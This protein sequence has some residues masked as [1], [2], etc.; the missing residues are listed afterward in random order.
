MKSI[1]INLRNKIR[2]A[3][4]TLGLMSRNWTS[5]SRVVAP[6]GPVV[7]LTTYGQRARTVFLTLESIARGDIQPSRLILWIDEDRLL[8]RIS[9][10]LRRLQRRGLEILRCED[11]GP[12]KKYYPY[13]R[14]HAEEGVSLVTA[15]DDV[16]YSREWLA[17]L[18]AEAEKDPE[19]VICFRAREIP[20]ERAD[21][22]LWLGDYSTWPLCA[23]AVAGP[24]VFP[25][26]T[27]GVLYP[28]AVQRVIRDAGNGA[29]T[30]FRFVDDVWLH[31]KTIAA[32]HSARQVSSRAVHFPMIF[33]T[34]RTALFRRNVYSNENDERVALA[35]TPDLVQ[36]IAGGIPR[37]GGAPGV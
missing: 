30:A 22:A 32:G 8:D 3:G 15:D 10:P 25:T 16:L 11:L 13:V 31:S 37:K 26:G 4:M 9:G 1:L 35:Y 20:I 27:S 29:E 12:H 34:Q 28:P 7:S 17:V 14:D 6:G 5:T 2:K 18:S 19:S 24:Q 21:D 23:S 33:L 36:R